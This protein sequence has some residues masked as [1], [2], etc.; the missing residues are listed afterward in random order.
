M[1]DSVAN[2]KHH[3]RARAQTDTMHRAHHGEPPI[4]GALCSHALTYFVVE[5]LSAAAR[6][7]VESRI[8]QARHDRLVIQTR[9]ERKVMNLRRSEAGKLKSRILPPESA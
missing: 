8:F 3:G 2:S 4:S 7:T 5:N 9:D 6:Q 1:L